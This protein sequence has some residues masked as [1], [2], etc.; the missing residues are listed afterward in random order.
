MNDGADCIIILLYTI[1]LN[2]NY[3]IYRFYLNTKKEYY[4]RTIKPT[5]NNLEHNENR[6]AFYKNEKKNS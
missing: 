3:K 5:L 6:L 2:K 4:L 1:C